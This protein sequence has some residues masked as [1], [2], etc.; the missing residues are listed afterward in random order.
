MNT[1]DYGWFFR[2]WDIHLHTLELTKDSWA[3]IKPWTNVNLGSLKGNDEADAILHKQGANVRHD[4]D[5]CYYN[6]TKDII[7]M[8]EPQRFAAILPQRSELLPMLV[9]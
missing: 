8:P 1:P 4:G 2:C 3:W 5:Q 6:I 9:P 7:I